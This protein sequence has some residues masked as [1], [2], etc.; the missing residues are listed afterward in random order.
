[1]M[2]TKK[3]PGKYPDLNEIIDRVSDDAQ[4]EYIRKKN[5]ETIQGIIDGY[6]VKV[7]YESGSDI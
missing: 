7:T 2:L 4:R 5:E 6:D 1:V 3:E